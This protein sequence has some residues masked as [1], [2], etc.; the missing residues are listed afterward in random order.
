MVRYR[1]FGS[2]SSLRFLAR[3]VESDEQVIAESGVNLC[4]EKPRN[5]DAHV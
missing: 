3:G 5:P 4:K 1:F 2:V